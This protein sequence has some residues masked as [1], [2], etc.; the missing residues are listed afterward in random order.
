MVDYTR[1]VDLIHEYTN[2]TS[3]VLSYEN[4]KVFVDMASDD[5]YRDLRI[6]P[7]EEVLT[8]P[9]S[10]ADTDSLE[11][12]DDLIEFIQLR[13]LDDAGNIDTIYNT[14]SDIRSHYL[15]NT[16]K[17][18]QNYYSREADK[19]LVHPEVK[20]GDVH[21]LYYYRRLPPIY[22]RFAVNEDNWNA[23]LLYYG[24]SQ[25]E[26]ENAVK[27]QDPNAFIR[28]PDLQSQIQFAP[29]STE[30]GST[31]KSGYYLGLLAQNWIRDE[32]LKMLLYGTLRE[33]YI[34]LKD[35]DKAAAAGA[36][37]DADVQKLNEESEL[38]RVRGGVAQ[39]HFSSNGLL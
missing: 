12:P 35:V 6:P 21:Q 32:N 14:R 1:F 23:N 27:A 10:T 30:P 15:S 7:L 36:L 8:Y 13:K 38:R 20:E 29:A 39:T 3:E 28:D 17:Y 16:S 33:C 22:A 9:A 24:A 4:I 5:I 25:Q 18:G 26:V 11:I 2:R 19:I 34:F 31:F 37:R